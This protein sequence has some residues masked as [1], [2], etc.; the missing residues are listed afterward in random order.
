LS[1]LSLLITSSDYRLR[2][3][4]DSLIGLSSGAALRLQLAGP[5]LTPQQIMMYGPG[6][7]ELV[8]GTAVSDDPDPS[9]RRLRE[10]STVELSFEEGGRV[11]VGQA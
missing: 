4:H 9:S 7:S 10:V 1:I 3:T 2:A 5:G 11:P 6:R 8:E